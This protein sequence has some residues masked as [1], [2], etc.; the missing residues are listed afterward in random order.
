MTVRIQYDH[1]SV[2]VTTLFGL[3]PAHGHDTFGLSESGGL[4]PP[5]SSEKVELKGITTRF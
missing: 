4:G 5:W 2:W 3:C 1:T